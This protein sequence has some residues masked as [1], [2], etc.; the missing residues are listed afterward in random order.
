MGDIQISAEDQRLLGIERL[1]IF[2]ERILPF[3]AVIE[4]F[5]LLL[6]IRRVAAD[7]VEIVVF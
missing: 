3:H 5:K 6:G 2:P 7:E 4:P 1:Q